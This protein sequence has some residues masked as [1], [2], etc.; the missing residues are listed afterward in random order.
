MP[1]KINDLRV[2]ISGKNKTHLN[3][4]IDRFFMENGQRMEYKI[5]LGRSPD[6]LSKKVNE[7]IEN[8][9][10]PQ[11]GLVKNDMGMA[12]A[13]VRNVVAKLLVDQPSSPRKS[14]FR[15]G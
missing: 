13:M 11:G 7:E 15:K 14:Q 2:S 10:R 3:E 1:Y 9:W 6:G 4:E 12:Q 8:G 5:V